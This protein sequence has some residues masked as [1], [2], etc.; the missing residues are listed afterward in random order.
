MVVNFLYMSFLLCCRSIQN[1]A[2]LLLVHDNVVEGHALRV[3]ADRGIGRGF[4]IPGNCYSHHADH[5]AA[6]ENTNTNSA[7]MSIIFFMRISFSEIGSG[8]VVTA[9][10]RQR[11]CS[12][13]GPAR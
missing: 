8:G 10:Q 7:K 11:D 5:C 9:C 12:L 1:Q 2:L 3:D 6:A 13:P 4:S